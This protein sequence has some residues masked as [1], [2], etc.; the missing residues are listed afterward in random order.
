[1]SPVQERGRKWLH[2]DIAV[3][4]Q[5]SVRLTFSRDREMMIPPRPAPSAPTAPVST[6]PAPGGV[7]AQ[8]STS[9]VNK[10]ANQIPKGFQE[11]TARLRR[12]AAENLK[13]QQWTNERDPGAGKREFRPPP[14]IPVRSYSAPR[15]SRSP[16]NGSPRERD[17]LLPD[18]DHGG[19]GRP[20]YR[21][22]SP[23]AFGRSDY[24]DQAL[25]G[26][27]EPIMSRRDRWLLAAAEEDLYSPRAAT[28][29]PGSPAGVG[30]A[31]RRGDIHRLRAPDED[32]PLHGGIV[33]ARNSNSIS[34]RKPRPL[35]GNVE[36]HHAEKVAQRAERA[37]GGAPPP[38]STNHF[39]RGR[40]DAAGTQSQLQRGSSRNKNPS[41]APLPDGRGTMN[42]SRPSG[43]RAY[44]P[45]DSEVML[46][47]DVNISP[48]RTER[49]TVY[50]NQTTEG[51]ARDFA[52]LHKLDGRLTLKLIFLLQNQMDSLNLA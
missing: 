21:H 4:N 51:A 24:R 32:S 52:R 18:S 35:H 22:P 7:V 46:Y 13:K 41:R 27:Y 16:E 47:V 28:S 40:Q 33:P 31:E 39:S 17:H 26:L 20:D 45:P 30:A 9:S 44:D 49:L 36:E 1:M 11:T 34:T 10:R 25:H 23:I 50:R 38:R 2:Y 19:H 12:A 43:A 48:E 8:T 6:G 5:C 14:R 3:R 29:S 37:T 42:S 15:S